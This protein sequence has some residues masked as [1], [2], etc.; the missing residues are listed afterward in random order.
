MA[1]IIGL[2]ASYGL[3]LVSKVI[4]EKGKDVLEK[5]F[6][7]KIPDDPQQI[8]KNPELVTKLKYIEEKHDIELMKLLLQDRKLSMTDVQ[9]A[10]I[11]RTKILTSDK[12]PMLN[13]IYPP[14]LATIAVVS[15]FFLFGFLLFHEVTQ[16]QKDV[17]LY[18]L[19][20][21]SSINAQIFSFYFGSSMGSKEK[22]EMIKSI[23]SMSD[24]KNKY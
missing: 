17:V 8:Q 20:V 10:R 18:L 21:L 16:T 3:N 1:P 4:Q 12:V 19:G 22:T 14:I 5:K 6:G 15:T 24:S 13:K 23:N 7:V 11:N 2:L 9:D